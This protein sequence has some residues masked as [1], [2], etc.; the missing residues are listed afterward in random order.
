MAVFHNL[1]SGIVLQTY[2]IVRLVSG[3]LAP[4]HDGTELA[5]PR[6]VKNHVDDRPRGNCDR[7]GDEIEV[8]AQLSAE[9]RQDD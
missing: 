2:R 7:I 3:D 1:G 8:D 5:V 4:T 9:H 6:D